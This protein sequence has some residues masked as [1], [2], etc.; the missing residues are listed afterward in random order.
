MDYKKLPFFLR[1]FYAERHLLQLYHDNLYRIK[2]YPIEKTHSGN[3]SK[4]LSINTLVGYGGAARAAYEMLTVQLNK[5]GQYEN[6]ILTNENRQKLD[7]HHIYMMPKIYSRHA[8]KSLIK[9]FKNYG[10]LD[11]SRAETYQIRDLD[12]FK[13]CDLLHFH[14]LHGGYFSP[15]VLPEMT[16]L[17]PTVYTLHDM[18]SFTG[19]CSHSKECAKWVDGCCDCPDLN[20]Y[21]ALAN[22]TTSEIWNVLKRI[23]NSCQLISFVTPSEWLKKQAEKSI[24]KDHDIRCIPNGIDESKYF[25]HESVSVRNELDLP[26]D[27]K[28]LLFAADGGEDNPGK[29]AYYIKNAYNALRD[30]YNVLFVEI[31]GSET[32]YISEDYLKIK[33]IVEQDTMAKYYSAADLFIYPTFADTFPF[34]VLEAMG[35]G[36]PV[37][38]FDVG[39]VPEQIKHSKTGYI[40]EYMN[41]EDFTKGIK[42]FLD[43]EILLKSASLESRQHVLDNFTTDKCVKRYSELYEEVFKRRG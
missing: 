24:I 30:N 27:K 7:D 9:A 23:Y 33:Y 20:Y 3:L 12:V 10:Y 4:I 38:S 29:G 14:N 6:N 32:K 34:V 2:K 28:I 17:K 31:G 22:D 19:H 35:C 8:K 15:F 26:Q 36:T 18:C 37:I 39:G 5:Q 21:P 42:L 41:I 13:Q 11:F 43:N 25:P 40:A 1:K 16:A